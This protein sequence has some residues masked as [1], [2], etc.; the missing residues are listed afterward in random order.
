MADHE[1][2]GPVS[3]VPTIRTFETGGTAANAGL[4][5]GGAAPTGE[6]AQP[7]TREGKPAWGAGPGKRATRRPVG[8]PE[9]RAAFRASWKAAT[10]AAD[11]MLAA[12]R[13]GD[14][15]ELAVA[16]DN[17]DLALGK[18]W[19]LRAARDVNW[20]TILNHAQGM[21]RELFAAK[22]VEQLTAE[23]CGAILELVDRYLGPST[24]TVVDL[25][26]AVR[27]IED[28]GFDP[29]AAISGDPADGDDE[30]DSRG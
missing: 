4:G 7:V 6:G 26:E 21:L 20:K 2:R 1:G 13:S 30:D 28:A 9:H 25:N 10:Q 15:M 27:L 29:Y 16:A 14:I 18:L 23:Q 19:G 8:S 5:G 11:E 22:Q 12:A 17:L 24:K 3:I